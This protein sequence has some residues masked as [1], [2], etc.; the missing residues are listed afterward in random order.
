[1]SS[2]GPPRKATSRTRLLRQLRAKQL[3]AAAARPWS[4]R[5]FLPA[6]GTA[7]RV[8]QAP[9]DMHQSNTKPINILGPR[10]RLTPIGGRSGRGR[11]RRDAAFVMLPRSIFAP[12]LS[13]CDGEGV[14]G[15]ENHA[16]FSGMR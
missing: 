1:M 8:G 7:Y 10:L 15:G 14:G 3:P 12:A 4:R 2:S 6:P 13:I 5:R 11:T 9:P 16:E